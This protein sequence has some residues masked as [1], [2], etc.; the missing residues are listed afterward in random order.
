MVTREILHVVVGG[1]ENGGDDLGDLDAV[2]VGAEAEVDAIELVLHV[3]ALVP[4]AVLQGVERDVDDV[5]DVLHGCR[6]C[7]GRRP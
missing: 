7:S 4:E 1:V 3:A 2:G 5:V 6:R